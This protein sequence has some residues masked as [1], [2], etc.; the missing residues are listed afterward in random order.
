[1]WASCIKWTYHTKALELD[2]QGTLS[3]AFESTPV[4]FHNM[5]YLTTPFNQV[6]ALDAVT[7]AEKWT[8]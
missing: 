7:G 5:L 8:L 6:I 2:R 1:M 3:A 4:L